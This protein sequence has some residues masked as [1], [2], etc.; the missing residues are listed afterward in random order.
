[1]SS[2]KKVRESPVG[3]HWMNLYQNCARK[4]FIKYPMGFTPFYT[5]PPLTEGAA[6][7]AGKAHFYKH[8]SAD[9]A[10]KLIER[11]LRAC[12]NDYQDP[13]DFDKALYW[14]PTLF[15]HWVLDWGELDLQTYDILEVEVQ[16]KATLPNGFY[17]TVRPDAVVRRK[18]NHKIYIMETKTTRY[19]WLVTE[20]GVVYGDQA[21]SYIYAVKQA[22]PSWHLEGVIPDISYWHKSSSDPTKINNYRGQVVRRDPEQ[23]RQFGLSTMNVISDISQR[24]K[25]VQQGMDPVAAFPRNTQWC[26]S[27]NRLCEY[28]HICRQDL[29]PGRVPAGFLR[30]PWAEKHQ[31]L[32]FKRGGRSGAVGVTKEKAAQIQA[33]GSYRAVGAAVRR[34]LRL[35]QTG[36]G[37]VAR[38]RPEHGLVGHRGHVRDG[39]AQLLHSGVFRWIPPSR[40]KRYISALTDGYGGKES[41]DGRSSGGNKG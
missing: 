22:H 37:S 23:L 26:V 8:G 7:H 39:F 25:A 16:R 14:V 20:Q 6:F 4:F 27:Y 3:Y 9:A 15:L 1:M 24:V 32:Q 31:V 17:I 40:W 12:K 18:D 11:Q 38:S 28:A 30:D 10:R 35:R 5:E 29:A 19:S 2:R 34:E 36:P 41:G 21:T 13:K 33:V